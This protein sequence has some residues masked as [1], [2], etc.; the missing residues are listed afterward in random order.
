MVGPEG[1]SDDVRLAR[2]RSAAD[3]SLSMTISNHKS[4]YGVAFAETGDL[5][6]LVSTATP[7]PGATLSRCTYQPHEEFNE[8]S[9]CGMTI[10]RTNSRRSTLQ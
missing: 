2:V 9:S 8:L 7:T 1:Y 4:A 3:L 6:L 5:F 10:A